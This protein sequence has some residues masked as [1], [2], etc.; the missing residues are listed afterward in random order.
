MGGNV[1]IM[2]DDDGDDAT[3][4]RFVYRTICENR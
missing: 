3:A 4:R 2:V 1:G